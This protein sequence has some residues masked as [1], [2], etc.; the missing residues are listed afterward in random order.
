LKFG[1]EIGKGEEIFDNGFM[2]GIQSDAARLQQ[3]PH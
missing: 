2:G 3:Y 1:V